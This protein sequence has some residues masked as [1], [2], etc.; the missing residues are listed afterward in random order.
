MGFFHFASVGE[1]DGLDVVGGVG[2]PESDLGSAGEFVF[3]VGGGLDAGGLV[4]G[5]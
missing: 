1:A 3:E 2:G 4:V 5:F